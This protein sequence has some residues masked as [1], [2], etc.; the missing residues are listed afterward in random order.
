MS[1]IILDRDGVINEDSELF[2][3]NEQEWIALPGSIAAIAELSKAGFDV[4]IATNQSGL[5]RGL[6]SERDLEAMHGKLRRLVTEQGGQIAGIFYC[7]HAPDAGCDCRKPAPGLLWQIQTHAGRSVR[8]APMIGDSLR[9]LEAGVAA[10]CK[11]I[12]VKTGKGELTWQKIEREGIEDIE[13][14]PFKEDL[15]VFNN[16]AQATQALVAGQI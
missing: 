5:G 10:G 6:F 9:D 15:L 2:I 13:G 8:G 4:Y 1:L 12:L 3:K 16:L 14:I 7:P 11:P